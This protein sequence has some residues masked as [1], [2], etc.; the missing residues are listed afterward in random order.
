[1]FVFLV[2]WTPF[3]LLLLAFRIMMFFVCALL[4]GIA[5]KCGCGVQWIRL[6][7]PI[8]G[9]LVKVHELHHL[10]DSKSPLIIANHVS[11]FDACMVWAANPPGEQ[12]LVVNDHWRPV[13]STVQCLG[14]PINPIY[15]TE[16]STKEAITTALAAEVRRADMKKMLLFPEGRTTS[17]ITVMTFFEFAFTLNYPIVPCTI[18]IYNPWPIHVQS[19]GCSVIRNLVAF[20]FLPCIWYKITFHQDVDAAGQAK[21][22][23]ASVRK[24]ICE[25]LD[26]PATT[27]GAKDKVAFATTRNKKSVVI[28]N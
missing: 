4:Y 18:E 14:W 23:A 8:F 1:M 28:P 24:L 21:D 27:L 19:N 10:N 6:I 16:G 3:G 26:V 2:L 13:I 12:I 22:R 9:A 7:Q 20:Y 15:T 25:H 17:G 5:H 11:D